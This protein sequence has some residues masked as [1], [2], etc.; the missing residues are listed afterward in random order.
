MFNRIRDSF[1]LF[2]NRK[3]DR[4]FFMPLHHVKKFG[5]IY[6]SFLA[7]VV[8][9][10]GKYSPKPLGHSYGVEQ[11][12]DGIAVAAHTLS[13]SD[14][15]RVFSRNIEKKDYKAIQL[16]LS[17]HSD[18]T[19]ILNGASI[20]LNLEPVRYVARD[21]HLNVVKRTVT[22]VVPGIL[23]MPVLF[24]MIYVGLVDGT[25][26][27]IANRN[28]N[29]DFE[30][31]CIDRNARLYLHPGKTI[32]KVMFV[33]QENFYKKLKFTVESLDGARQDLAYTI[34]L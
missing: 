11:E 20:N 10:C 5:L 31:R 1:N 22:W 28:L 24:P 9:G 34:A 6:L 21:M 7:F 27:A 26:S 23:L 2:H 30:Q 3:I 13:Y 29:N 15:R 18:Q 32:T 33:R 14:C 8:P 16:T 4:L 25:K 12:L 19:Y 17:N